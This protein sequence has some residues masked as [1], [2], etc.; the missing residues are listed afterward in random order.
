MR[1]TQELPYRAGGARQLASPVAPRCGTRDDP[2]TVRRL[3]LVVLC[4]AVTLVRA[5]DDLLA[6]LRS[7]HP[8]LLV[9]GN[10][11]WEPFNQARATYPEYEAFLAAN[12]AAARLILDEPVVERRL[13]GRRLLHVSRTVLE[14]TLT[15]IVA[16]RSTGETIFAVRAEQELQ[17]ATAFS[18][19]NPDHFLDVAEMATAVA[20]S[21]DWLFDALRP[22]SRA[23]LRQALVEKALRP[24]L[25][26][27]AKPG[28]W[29]TAENNWN[30]VCWSGLAIAALAIADEEPTLART[31][32]VAA[33]TNIVHGLKPYAP[34]GVYPEGPGYWGYGTTYQVLLLAALES[35]LDSDWDLTSAPGFL[36]SAGAQLQLTG[37][38]GRLFNFADGREPGALQ[39]ALFWIA[40]R[41]R[42]PGLIRGQ[43]RFLGD[44]PTDPAALDA[45][46]ETARFR[47]LVALWWP[48]RGFTTTPLLPLAWHGRGA[49]PVA[50][51]R[52][53]WSD[54]A[55]LYLAVKA[56]SAGLSHAHMDAGSFVLE[57][58]GVRWAIDLGMQDYESLESR[59]IDLWNRRQDSP[60]WRVFRLNNHSH[61][62]LTLGGQL[63]RVDGAAI[64]TAFS[65][66]QPA[67]GASIDLTPVFAGQAERATRRL[68]VRD[69]KRV[70][71]RD[72]LSGLAP[73]TAI[74]WAMATRAAV[75]SNGTSATL[76]QGG[77][78]LRAT[79]G[80]APGARF[81]AIPATP[82]HGFDAPNPGVTL[83]LVD[84]SAP[85][86]GAV[87]I[88]VEL[89]LAE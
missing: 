75:A 35:A 18:D 87:E 46:R 79:L 62:T 70:V 57:A 85:A 16:Y 67:P 6:N 20:I 74:R 64:F 28:G 69:D 2:A 23:A 1:H 77:R 61:N 82:P 50:V 42:D 45:Y 66:E 9:T 59:G 15:L 34:D 43:E 89:A 83:L 38:S 21:Y 76:Q 29:P 51:F 86:S 49:N 40:R 31:V 48:E 11:W 71:V 53:S 44:A 47:P 22:D 68:D 30:Q 41:Y 10:T 81:E 17:A 39:P 36:V 65:A 12:E 80:A 72:S 5:D 14:R 8:R 25:A 33:R 3:L 13:T 60:R 55:A 24:G 26:A 7:G 27:A 19:W 32:L 52:S 84:T 37:P 63:H 58:G 73:G 56:G 54:P 88:E 78:T 4:F